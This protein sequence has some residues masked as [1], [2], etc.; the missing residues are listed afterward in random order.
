MKM[1]RLAFAALLSATIG[2]AANAQQQPTTPAQKGSNAA[3]EDCARMHNKKHEH[4]TDRG[5]GKMA[6]QPCAPAAGASAPAKKMRKTHDS[7]KPA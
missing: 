4:G 7:R 1:S 3:P 2:V 6:M 5:A